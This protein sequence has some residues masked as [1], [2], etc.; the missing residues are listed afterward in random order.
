MDPMELL[1]EAQLLFVN[2]KHKESV[3]AFTKAIEAG[4]EP[5]IAYLSRGAA[6]LKSDEAD[7]AIHDFTRAID[8]NSQSARAYYFRG[9]V[10]LMREEFEQ[11][12]SDFSKALELKTD[13]AIAKFS[14]SVAYARMNMTEEASKDMKEIMPQMEENIQSFADSHGIIRTQLTKVMGQLEGDRPWPNLN[15]GEK[16]MEMLKKWLGEE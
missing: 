5:Y 2:G 12:V 7:K 9:I 14:R 6:N 8:A 3:E 4:A 1:K 13:Y 16:D 15:L 11:A 10:Y